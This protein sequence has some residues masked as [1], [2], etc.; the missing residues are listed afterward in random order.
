MVTLTLGELLAQKEQYDKQYPHGESDMQPRVQQ[1]YHNLL[2]EIR[3]AAGRAQ[4][5]LPGLDLPQPAPAG[6]MTLF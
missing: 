1:A 4:G 2:A 3:G 6:Q 5:V